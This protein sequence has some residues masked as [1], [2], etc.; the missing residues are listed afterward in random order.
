L[1]T[2]FEIVDFRATF[3]RQEPQRTENNHAFNLPSSTLRR[4]GAAGGFNSTGMEPISLT[5]L[6]MK[7]GGKYS[8]IFNL[9]KKGKTEKKT[10]DKMAKCGKKKLN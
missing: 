2:R 9:E 7:T 1:Y 3:A 10:L 5:E 6:L 4:E 8:F